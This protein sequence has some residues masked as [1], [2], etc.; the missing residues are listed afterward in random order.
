MFPKWESESER[1]EAGCIFYIGVALIVGAVLFTV[2]KMSG[3]L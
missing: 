2:L 1:N 3:A